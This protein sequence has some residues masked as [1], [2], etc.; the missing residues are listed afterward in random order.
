MGQTTYKMRQTSSKFELADAATASNKV[1]L[2]LTRSVTWLTFD[3]GVKT[4]SEQSAVT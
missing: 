2:E 3:R 4:V 1:L